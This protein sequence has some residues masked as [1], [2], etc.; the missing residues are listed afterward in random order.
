MR[1][2]HEE[3]ALLERRARLDRLFTRNGGGLHRI[4][5]KAG[6]VTLRHFTEADARS[7]GK[8][9]IFRKRTPFG[10]SCRGCCAWR[11]VEKKQRHKLIRRIPADKLPPGRMGQW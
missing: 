5:D 10:C 6:V 3:E 7:Y 1:R 2:W 11:A 8:R 4:V 9:G